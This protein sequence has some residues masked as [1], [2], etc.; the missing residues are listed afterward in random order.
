MIELIVIASNAQALTLLEE[1]TAPGL[2]AITLEDASANQSVEESISLLNVSN[3][4]ENMPVWD[5]VQL[6]LLFEDWESTQEGLPILYG[7]GVT[8]NQ[9]AGFRVVGDK[10]WI[11]HI[12]DQFHP[13]EIMYGFWLVPTWHEVPQ[14]AKNYLFLDPGLAFGTGSH[15]TTL[16]CLRWLL[17]H[18]LQDQSLLD[19]GCG[20][21]IL[22]MVAAKLSARPVYAV[23]ID[24]VAVTVTLDNARLNQVMIHAQTPGKLDRQFHLV[25]ANIVCQPLI[26]LAPHLIESLQIGGTLILSGIL[27]FQVE[28]IKNTYKQW[29]DLE[30]V[31]NIGD[32]VCLAGQYRQDQV[33][34]K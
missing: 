13:I 27:L 32:W 7:Y 3:A 17:N 25:M 6:F 33:A 26:D 29:L 9:L 28:A 1:F 11:E 21:G 12:K 4:Q 5:C 30:V 34:L 22:A 19:Y 24:T 15:P 10:D 16:M 31:D 2:L 18:N 8:E 20:S 14:E 23:D